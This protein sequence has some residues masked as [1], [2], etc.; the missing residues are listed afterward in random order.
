MKVNGG[1]DKNIFRRPVE[2]KDC[3]QWFQEGKPGEDMEYGDWL[4]T[5]LCN[6]IE[7]ESKEIGQ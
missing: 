4:K 6:L 3:F 1:I 7:E 2:I 5:T